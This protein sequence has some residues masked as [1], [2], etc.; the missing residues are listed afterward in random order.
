MNK[1]IFAVLP[2]AVLVGCA[3]VPT[4][5]PM[6]SQTEASLAKAISIILAKASS[7]LHLPNQPLNLHLKLTQKIT[8]RV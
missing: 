8:E 5:E 1:L 3:T 2:L 4:S 7:A 6:T